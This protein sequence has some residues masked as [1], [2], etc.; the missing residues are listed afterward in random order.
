MALPPV[1]LLPLCFLV[2][3]E[4]VGWQAVL[5]TSVALAGVALMFLAP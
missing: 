3:R 2:F 4:R 1:F 5:G